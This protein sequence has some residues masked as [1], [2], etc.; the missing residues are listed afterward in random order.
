[1]LMSTDKL[2]EKIE[3]LSVSNMRLSAD[4]AK[5]TAINESMAKDRARLC[6][7][8]VDAQNEAED[9]RLRSLKKAIEREQMPDGAEARALRDEID[10]LCCKLDELERRYAELKISHQ[11]VL[12]TNIRQGSELLTYERAKK[13]AD[14][15]LAKENASQ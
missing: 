4:L 12:A 15:A 10:D 8:L 5:V 14:V 1:M 9:M 11:V 7:K 2:N 6:E 13:M 3:Q